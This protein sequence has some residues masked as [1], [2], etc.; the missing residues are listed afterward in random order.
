MK[1]GCIFYLYR[2]K[3]ND[4]EKKGFFWPQEPIAEIYIP[5]KDLPC[6]HTIQGVNSECTINLTDYF[7][8]DFYT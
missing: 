8:S 1:N 5:V 3:K 6:I 4:K 2:I 7:L